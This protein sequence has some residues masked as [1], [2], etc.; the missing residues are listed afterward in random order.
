MNAVI[1]REKEPFQANRYTTG[2]PEYSS[3]EQEQ[4]GPFH[5][6]QPSKNGFSCPN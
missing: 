3:L 5:Q 6:H 1:P 2:P 4:H